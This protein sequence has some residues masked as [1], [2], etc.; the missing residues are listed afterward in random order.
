[1]MKKHITARLFGVL[2][3]ALL[4]AG[5]TT[6]TQVAQQPPTPDLGMV[7][8]E[9]AQ[10]VVVKITLEAALNPS[11]TPEAPAAQENVEPQVVQAATATPMPTETAVVEVPTVT[12]FPTATSRVSSSTGAG[13]SP[14]RTPRRIPDA[15]VLISYAP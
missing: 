2:A 10:T 6:S 4:G 5:C 12:A 11:A 8:T 14:T 9:A 7:R 13:I 3:L 1:M 15:A